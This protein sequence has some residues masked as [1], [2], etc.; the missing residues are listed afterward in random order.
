MFMGYYQK[1]EHLFNKIMDDM[2]FNM[3]FDDL[4]ELSQAIAHLQIAKAEIKEFLVDNKEEME[5]IWP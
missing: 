3:F 5:D 2:C 1:P 4:N